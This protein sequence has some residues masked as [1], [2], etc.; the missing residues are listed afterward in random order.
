MVILSNLVNDIRPY[1]NSSTVQ[2][3]QLLSNKAMMAILNSFERIA[4]ET[5][6]VSSMISSN[7]LQLKQSSRRSAPLRQGDGYSQQFCEQH[8]DCI[9]TEAPF[10]DRIVHRKTWASTYD[11]K[12]CFRTSR[13]SALPQ[14]NF[15]FDCVPKI[16]G[17][18][19]PP[20]FC[21]FSMRLRQSE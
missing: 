3:R 18:S 20:L 19:F 13:F 7:I 14:R 10:K 15:E 8:L 2:R 21:V 1:Y 6:S 5:R 11:P 17:F 4:A 9:S 16:S 12:Y